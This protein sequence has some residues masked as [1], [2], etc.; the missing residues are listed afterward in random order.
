VFQGVSPSV[1]K[2]MAA[3]LTGESWPKGCQV[4]TPD[5]QPDRFRIIASGRVKITRSNGHSGRELTLW[6]L[7]PGDGFDIV[8]LLDGAP[9]AVGAWTLEE[10]QTLYAPLDVVRMWLERYP[11]FRLAVHRYVG[12][13]LRRLADLASELAL[14]DT[15]TRLA[16]LLLRHFET[17]PPHNGPRLELLQ[18]LPQEELASLIGSVRV[19]VSRL[20]AQLRREA[21]VELRNGAVRIAD[22]K[23]LLQLAEVQLARRFARSARGRASG[24]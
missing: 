6:L 24:R 23:R 8:S 3:G 16:H 21:V 15:M 12:Q 5:G 20:L 22:L 17:T 14:H 10:V 18:D 2:K 19:V 7:G 4:S 9:H 1:L 13:Q 11:A